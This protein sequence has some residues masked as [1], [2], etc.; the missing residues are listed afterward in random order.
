M[1]PFSFQPDL[2]IEV[3]RHFFETSLVIYNFFP[4]F[5][6]NN[7]FLYVKKYGPILSVEQETIVGKV[8]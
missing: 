2:A 4:C 7:K 5:E 6:L 1:V 8:N 3:N